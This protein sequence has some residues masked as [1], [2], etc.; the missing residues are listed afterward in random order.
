M[1]VFPGLETYPDHRMF[2]GPVPLAV[3]RQAAEQLR[4]ALEELLQRVDQK[5]F[6]KRRGR[7]RK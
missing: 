7:D 5:V 2:D 3:D 4:V 1:T 6:P